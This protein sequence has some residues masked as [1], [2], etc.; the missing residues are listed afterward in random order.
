MRNLVSGITIYRIHKTYTVSSP[1]GNKKLKKTL[2]DCKNKR[3][4]LKENR[5]Q[6]SEETK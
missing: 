2:K 6:N 5:T 4:Q 1:N 3:L